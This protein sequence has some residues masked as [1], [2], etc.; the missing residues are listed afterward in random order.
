MFE[1]I[2]GLVEPMDLVEIKMAH[3]PS[4]YPN[5]LPIVM[6]GFVTAVSRNEVMADG[7][8]KRVITIGG[9][10]YGKLFQILQIYYLANSTVGDNIV[11]GLKFF[12]KFFGPNEAKHM[13]AEEFVNT[14]LSDVINPYLAKLSAASESAIK[15]FTPDITI[16]GQV[17]PYTVTTF[18]DVPVYAM[19]RGVLDVGAWNELYVE[20]RDNS[21]ALVVRPIPYKTPAGDFIQGTADSA[22]ISSEDIT[23]LNVTRTDQ[24]VANYFWVMNTRWQILLN[25][26]AK[27]AASQGPEDDFISF[28]YQNTSIEHYGIRKMEMES[29]LGPPGYSSGDSVKEAKLPNEKKT[30]SDWF[31]ERRRVLKALNQ[32]N[33][34]F[35][36]GSMHIRGNEAIKAGMY[37]QVSR[38]TGQDITGEYYVHK[39]EHVFRPFVNFTSTAFFDR[40]TGFITR[41]RKIIAPHLYEVE[42]QGVN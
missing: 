19:L 24:A 17:S 15:S 20:D 7:R 31:S 26:D 14:M 16:T 30:L 37:V 35:E 38:G 25:E 32:D 11:A 18:Q 4:D 1:S 2:Y 13:P 28:E 29:F 10:D 12:Y 23:L 42:A 41:S 5:G 9:Q 8:P 27:L 34:V 36:S 40:G 39:I 22:N 6:R 33:V 21:V 3:N